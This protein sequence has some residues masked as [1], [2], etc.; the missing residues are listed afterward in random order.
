[1]SVS[2]FKKE[3][4]ALNGKYQERYILSIQEVKRLIWKRSKKGSIYYYVKK[5]VMFF[6]ME[7]NQKLFYSRIN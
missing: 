3:N 5:V 2:E 6:F 7:V 1:M 4:L